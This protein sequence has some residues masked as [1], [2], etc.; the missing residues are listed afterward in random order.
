MITEDS[1]EQAHQEKL[2]AHS[3]VNEKDE[4]F[5]CQSCGQEFDE[6]QFCEHDWNIEHQWCKGCCEDS[7]YE[8][9]NREPHLDWNDL[10]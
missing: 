9:E 6:D 4:M 3:R 8:R 10:D 7:D 1:L 5:E 2:D